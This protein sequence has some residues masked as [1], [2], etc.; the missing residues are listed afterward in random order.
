MDSISTSYTRV[1]NVPM[2]GRFS[3]R[4]RLDWSNAGLV[5]RSGPLLFTAHRLLDHSTL[6]SSVIKKKKK[7][8]TETR[9]ILGSEGVGLRV[10]GYQ[11]FRFRRFTV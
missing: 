6:G 10:E 3:T 8:S 7:D 2:P 11:G 4:E 5:K 1:G 9:W